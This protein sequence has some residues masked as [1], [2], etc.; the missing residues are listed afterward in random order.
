MGIVFLAVPVADWAGSW[1]YEARWTSL[2]SVVLLLRLIESASQLY[3][4]LSYKDRDIQKGYLYPFKCS[5][6]H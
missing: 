5:E 3:P 4:S 2:I 1:I 6:I